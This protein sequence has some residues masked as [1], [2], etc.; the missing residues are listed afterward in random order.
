MKNHNSGNSRFMALKLNMS[1]AYDRVKWSFLKVV[2]SQMGFNDRWIGFIM[3]CVTTVTYSIVING[4]PSGEIRPGKGIRQG[5]LLSPYLFLLCSEGLHKLIQKAA[6]RSDIHGVS[7][8]RNGPKLIHLL[9]T[10]D[11]LLF[12][13][14]TTQ[15]CEKVMEI[16]SS[17]EKVLG[18][19]LNR[20]KIALFFSK[21][22]PSDVQR[23]IME[24]LEV[25]ELKQYE[26]YL[27]LP[28]MVG[29]NKRASFDKLKQRV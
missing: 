9:F 4:K 21:S 22:T 5:D 18:K 7:I 23:Q 17:Y 12:C 26:E 6:K 15:E 28:A 8:C 25:S 13:K 16:L 20:D 27:G 24:T 3:E 14:A 2:M 19:K 29:K 1:K 11:S 10:N